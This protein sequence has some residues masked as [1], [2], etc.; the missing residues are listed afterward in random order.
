[1]I[2]CEQQ[3]CGRGGGCTYLHA[4]KIF[5]TYLQNGENFGTYLQNVQI[6]KARKVESS[7]IGHVGLHFTILG[8]FSSKMGH[9]SPISSTFRRFCPL[10]GLF[11]EFFFDEPPPSLGKLEE[12]PQVEGY[13]YLV[14][15]KRVGR[16]LCTCRGGCGYRTT[17]EQS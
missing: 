11:P 4:R 16:Y 1:M 15:A 12:T 13:L 17:G 2:R 8:N 10:K 14:P 6:F 3:W 5:C 7:K 9:N